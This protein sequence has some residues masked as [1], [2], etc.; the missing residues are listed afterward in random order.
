MSLEANLVSLGVY[1]EMYSFLLT[2]DCSLDQFAPIE[3]SL[4][5]SLSASLVE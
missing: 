1:E 2:D 3:F 4:D 5:V